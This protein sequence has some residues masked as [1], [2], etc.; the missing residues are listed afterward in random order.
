M[1]LKKIISIQLNPMLPPDEKTTRLILDRRGNRTSSHQPLTNRALLFYNCY[2]AQI[3]TQ[4][5]FPPHPLDYILPP[6]HL[7]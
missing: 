4:P 3:P 6:T 7:F 5:H 1:C 2:Q